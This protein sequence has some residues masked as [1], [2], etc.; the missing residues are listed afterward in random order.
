MGVARA[1]SYEL[2]A[3]VYSYGV[4]LYELLSLKVAWE[5]FT[6]EEHEDM[7]V[8]GGQRPNLEENSWSLTLKSLI[9]MCWAKLSTKRPDFEHIIYILGR[10]HTALKCKDTHAL[11]AEK[12]SSSIAS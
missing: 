5:K 2:S 7:V 8:Y 12:R 4:L 11:E 3:D 10:E 9:N 1:S 6:F